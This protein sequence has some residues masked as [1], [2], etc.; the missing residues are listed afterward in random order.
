M[1][2]QVATELS[3]YGSYH[4]VSLVTADDAAYS[5]QAAMHLLIVVPHR[6]ALSSVMER[7]AETGN[8]P[9]TL[10]SLPIIMIV[11]D[12]IVTSLG[13]CTTAVRHRLAGPIV[14][15]RSRFVILPK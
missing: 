13:S 3:P 9:G 5:P 15:L 14:I 4:E 12:F 10:T 6:H 8:V 11:G 1:V 2:C 7:T